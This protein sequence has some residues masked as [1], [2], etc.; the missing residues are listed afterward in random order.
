MRIGFDR[1]GIGFIMPSVVFE[2]SSVLTLSLSICFA[3][4]HVLKAMKTL[5]FV[6]PGALNETVRSCIDPVSIVIEPKSNGLG[7]ASVVGAGGSVL[8][9]ISSTCSKR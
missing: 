4:E 7:A 5:C 8:Y 6:T 2:T 1:P 3:I 9:V